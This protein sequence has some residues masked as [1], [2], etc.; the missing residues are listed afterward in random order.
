MRKYA[1]THKRTNAYRRLLKRMRVFTNE[2]EFIYTFSMFFLCFLCR[3]RGRLKTHEQIC[4]HLFYLNIYVSFS[5]MRSYCFLYNNLMS[6]FIYLILC[7]L[8]LNYLMYLSFILI[9]ISFPCFIHLS[10]LFLSLSSTAYTIPS[11]HDHLLHSL[12]ASS[13]AISILYCF[14]PTTTFP[15]FLFFSFP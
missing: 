1:P 8:I 5:S 12:L 6:F 15:S 4:V 10:F 7:F 13:L 2:P 3:K 14:P 11:I 9:L